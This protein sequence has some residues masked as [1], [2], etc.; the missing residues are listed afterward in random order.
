[1]TQTQRALR[2][3]YLLIFV[4]LCLLL[5]QFWPYIEAPEP[6]VLLFAALSSLTYA[7]IFLSPVMLTGWSLKCSFAP[8]AKP[9]HAGSWRWS[10]GLSACSA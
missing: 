2:R 7:A 1:V 9:F 3:F 6:T 5:V 8:A 10:M 4:V